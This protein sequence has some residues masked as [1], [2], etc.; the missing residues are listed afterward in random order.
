VC[1]LT[2]RTTVTHENTPDLTKVVRVHG[3]L[4]LALRL[5]SFLLSFVVVRLSL[6]ILGDYRY[7]IWSVLLS[8]LSWV[9]MMDVGVVHGVRNELAQ[10]FQNRDRHRASRA[11]STAYVILVALMLFAFLLILLFDRSADWNRVIG[12]KEL[13]SI[14]VRLSALL[15]W[16]FLCSLLPL[17]VVNA[18]AYGRQMAAVPAVIQLVT[19]G[20]F[21]GVLFYWSVSKTEVALPLITGAYAIASLSVLFFATLWFLATGSELRPR[22]RYYDHQTAQRLFSLGGQFFV[23]QLATI[24]IFTTDNLIVS[25]LLGPRSVTVYAVNHKLFS[26]VHLLF[27]MLLAPLWSAFTAAHTKGD[28]LWIKQR[29]S[30]LV[31]LFFAAVGGLLAISVLRYR[32]LDLWLTESVESPLSLAFSMVLMFGIMIWNNIFATYVN[33]ISRLRVQL[34]T[35]TVGAILNIPLSILF[36]RFFDLGVAGV[37]IATCVSLLPSAVWMTRDALSDLANSHAS[38]AS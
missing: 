38:T 7:G 36:V 12:A 24:V 33:G 8:M 19:Q 25:H 15:F 28:W 14:E 5:L 26:T 32:F 13:P 17:S 1:R 6:A 27:G 11:I 35:A 31:R 20:V 10:A 34:V 23:I 9:S 3:S 37:A 21:A 30:N 18:I 16:A 4:N 29:L 22:I 2:A